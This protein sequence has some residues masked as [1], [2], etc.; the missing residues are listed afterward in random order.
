MSWRRDCRSRSPHRCSPACP[1]RGSPGR[2]SAPR[3]Y[4][5]VSRSASPE[6]AR[7]GLARPFARFLRAL[8][9]APIPDGMPADPMGRADMQMRVPK[10]DES[11]IE[12]E[13]EGLWR[14]PD[15][16]RYLLEAAHELPPP[17][18]TV[19]AHGD[20]HMRHLLV[21]GD[22]EL[23]GVIDWGDVCRGD[24]SVDLSCCGACCRP[25]AAPSSSPSTAASPTTSSSAPASWRSSCPR[26]SR[27]T[28]TTR[29]WPRRSRR[30]LASSATE[31]G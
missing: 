5:A 24:P 13:P 15:P 19:V 10:T 9:S 25:T 21:D 28:A 1:P 26:S 31:L 8:H 4:P 18:P 30:S 29:A 3:T 27:S 7:R 14:T 16:V 2:G 20:L 6:A 23:T 22:G 17:E 11:L 12:L